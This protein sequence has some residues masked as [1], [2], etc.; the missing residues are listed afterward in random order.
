MHIITF[1]DG[2]TLDLDTTQGAYKYVGR[3]LIENGASSRVFECLA[4]L[5][6]SVEQQERELNKNK[7]KSGGCSECGRSPCSVCGK[8]PDT[9][10]GVC[11]FCDTMI[12]D[13]CGT[14]A[15]DNTFCSQACADE[16]AW[17]WL[18]DTPNDSS[19]SCRK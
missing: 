11:G 9:D 19:E 12:C 2:A 5:Y 3:F 17:T 15:H 16:Y 1:D 7:T 4:L 13:D 14:V 8:V 6:R 10:M 18:D